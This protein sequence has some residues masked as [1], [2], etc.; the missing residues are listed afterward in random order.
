MP[1][2]RY[3]ALNEEIEGLDHCLPDVVLAEQLEQA[4]QLGVLRVEKH[5]DVEDY[6]ALYPLRVFGREPETDR[7]APVLHD[8]RR[9]AQ[10]ERQQKRGKVLDVTGKP[11]PAFIERLV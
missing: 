11:V 9:V 7:A 3:P 5:P 6:E 8:E 10:V 1:P 4:V 2:G